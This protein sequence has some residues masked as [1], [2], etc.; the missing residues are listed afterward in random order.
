MSGSVPL[1]QV[2]LKG[3]ESMLE[4][5]EEEARQMEEKLKEEAARLTRRL[6]EERK[7][8][9]EAQVRWSHILEVQ[10][11][12]LLGSVFLIYGV[13]CLFFSKIRI[14]CNTYRG[15]RLPLGELLGLYK[16]S[17]DN[18]RQTADNREQLSENSC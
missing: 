17:C 7:K 3:K 4:E 16:N 15:R 14:P 2:K 12:K 13:F 18:R 10:H 6:E 9:V 11:S 8:V 5:V 1:P